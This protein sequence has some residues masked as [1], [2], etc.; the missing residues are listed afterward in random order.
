MNKNTIIDDEKY[1]N[2]FYI[3]FLYNSP[4]IEKVIVKINKNLYI[5]YPTIK[6]RNKKFIKLKY[7]TRILLQDEINWLLTDI[8][9]IKKMPLYIKIVN[10]LKF[11][12]RNIGQY[13]I[14]INIKNME[15]KIF[16]LGIKIYN[17]NSKYCEYCHE[18]MPDNYK[19]INGEDILSKKEIRKILKIK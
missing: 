18:A 12:Y 7:E 6:N 13:K 2:D 5:K 19:I 15:Y 9:T 16:F 3:D 8:D 4:D 11:I 17:F 14:I 1:F 10:K